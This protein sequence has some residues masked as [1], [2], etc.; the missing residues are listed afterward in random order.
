[1]LVVFLGFC[2]E[3]NPTPSGPTRFELG[4]VRKDRRFGANR[5]QSVQSLTLKGLTERTATLVPKRS[6]SG[7]S[8][9]SR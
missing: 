2:K 8:S 3:T 7:V 4:R 5:T 6:F 9:L 1:M